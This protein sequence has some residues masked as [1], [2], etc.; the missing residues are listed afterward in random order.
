MPDS[1]S[2]VPRPTPKSKSTEAELAKERNKKFWHIAD[3]KDA[4]KVC[5]LPLAFA[6]AVFSFY[7]DVWLRLRQQDAA[8]VNKVVD[9]LA[10]LQA[11]DQTIFSHQADGD[12]DSVAAVDAAQRGLRERLVSQAFDHWKRTPDFFQRGELDTLAHHLILQGRTRDA[13]QVIDALLAQ[14]R[15]PFERADVLLKKGRAHGAEGDAFD[16]AQAR[17][18]LRAA[19]EAAETIPARGTRLSA[20]T[21]IT[22]YSAF[23]ELWYEQPCE[24]IAPYMLALQEMSVAGTPAES[25]ID[26]DIAILQ[27]IYEG[28]CE[29]T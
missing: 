7:D 6:L 13:L 17:D 21:N 24:S 18:A 26:K 4:L 25:M 8:S 27:E 5:G 28:R 16:L 19:I 1:N 23:L 22:H 3:W 12:M 2:E 29:E 14:A 15:S 10:K 11:L 9:G 20:I